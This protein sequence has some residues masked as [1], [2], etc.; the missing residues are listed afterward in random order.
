MGASV[1]PKFRVASPAFSLDKVLERLATSNR[2]TLVVERLHDG[3]MRVT[4]SSWDH[5]RVLL[6]DQALESRQNDLKDRSIR[7]GCSRG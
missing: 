1:P 3:K 6:R 7:F 2:L 4:S 5:E